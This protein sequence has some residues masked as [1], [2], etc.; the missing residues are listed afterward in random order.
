MSEQNKRVVMTYVDAF[1][2]GDLDGVCAMFAPDALILGGFGWGGIERARPVWDALMRCFQM[3]LEMDAVVAEGDAVAVRYTERGRSV[4]SFQG[5]P[6][7]GKSYEVPAM[8][9]FVV[10]EGHIERC[11]SVR[12]TVEMFRQMALPL[13]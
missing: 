6:V 12:D 1:N 9:W 10:K 4:Q 2:R 13:P 3:S 7:T 11:W 8:E 5:G